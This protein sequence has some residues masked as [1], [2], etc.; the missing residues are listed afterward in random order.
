MTWWPMMHA[1]I[2]HAGMHL[3]QHAFPLRSRGGGEL[4]VEELY[5]LTQQL[6][7]SL[8]QDMNCYM[9]KMYQDILDDLGVTNPDSYTS[10]KLKSKLLNQFGYRVAILDQSGQAS[11]VICAALVPLCDVLAKLKQ[12]EHISHLD[13]K[14]ETLFRAATLL[15]ENAKLCGKERL[16]SYSIDV[17]LESAAVIV[18]DSFYNFTCILLSDRV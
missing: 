4:F 1:T 3:R 12:L 13:P 18:P 17:S 15:R 5:Q 11:G 6:E 14:Q 10:F 16:A 7:I 8:F 9:I 2:P